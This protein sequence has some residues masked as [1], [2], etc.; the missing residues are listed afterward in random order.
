MKRFIVILFC[1]VAL[2]GCGQRQTNSAS[3]DTDLLMNSP[4][5]SVGAKTPEGQRTAD[6]REVRAAIGAFYAAF[7]SHSFDRIAKHTTE[8]WVH[9]GPVGVVRR[10]RVAV[11]EALKQVHSTFLKGVTDTPEEVDVRFATS[12]VAVA[13]VPSRM[14]SFTSPDGVRHENEGRIRTFVVVKRGG[15]WLIMQDH[16]TVRSVD[17][18]TTNTNAVPRTNK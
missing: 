11:L 18:R 17:S 15:R 5:E 8:D 2:T 7:N 6:E 4:P 13:T 1:S 9:I 10:G 16:N 3:K 12:D 14:T